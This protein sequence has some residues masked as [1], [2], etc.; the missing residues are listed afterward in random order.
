MAIGYVYCDYT[1]VDDNRHTVLYEA[2]GGTAGE[3]P[4]SKY[5]GRSFDFKTSLIFPIKVENLLI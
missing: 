4:K 5:E 3:Y 2:V 1:T